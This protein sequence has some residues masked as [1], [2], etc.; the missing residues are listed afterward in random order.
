MNTSMIFYFME[1]DLLI[2]FRSAYIIL[3]SILS[4]KNS[5]I[6]ILFYGFKKGNNYF[7][8]FQQIMMNISEKNMSTLNFIEI[9][10]HFNVYFRNFDGNIFCYF[11][12][13]C[14]F[15]IEIYA[16][17]YM[18]IFYGNQLIFISLQEFWNL[19]GNFIS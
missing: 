18:H 13:W 10:F 17:S 9:I 2:C 7:I 5:I 3:F 4:S 14:W 1:C 6:Q 15:K 16:L 11:W 12:V 19:K 8:S